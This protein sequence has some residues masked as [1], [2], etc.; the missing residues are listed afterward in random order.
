MKREELDDV[1][2]LYDMRYSHI[3]AKMTSTGAVSR[4]MK[5]WSA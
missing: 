5:W 1:I 3:K 4:L 2:R